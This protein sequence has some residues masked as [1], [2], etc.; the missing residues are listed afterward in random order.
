MLH[1]G[2]CSLMFCPWQTLG[3][4]SSTADH[5]TIPLHPLLLITPRPG[6]QGKPKEVKSFSQPLQGSWAPRGSEAQ[7]LYSQTCL[8]LSPQAL[9]SGVTRWC[10]TTL[11]SETTARADSDKRADR[12]S[13]ARTQPQGLPWLG[14]REEGWHWGPEAESSL[15]KLR[16]AKRTGL[17]QARGSQ[18]LAAVFSQ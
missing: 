8:M 17:L 4:D 5:P 16:V 13:L 6:K 11:H 2:I 12:L 18:C 7:P 14:Q 9:Q 10:I 3:T 15:L 1:S